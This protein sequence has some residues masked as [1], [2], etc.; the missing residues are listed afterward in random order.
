MVRL[1]T[2]WCPLAEVDL[3]QL[4]EQATQG[5]RDALESLCRQLQHMVYRLALRFFSSPEDAEVAAQE[6]LVNVVA[7]LGSFEGRSKLTTWVYTIASRHLVR[8]RRRS[9]EASVQGGEAFGA[10]LGPQPRHNRLRRG[11]RSRIQASLW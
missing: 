3:E 10:W 11:H 7:N 6:I 9:V 4:A 5:D 2:A 1:W 8:S